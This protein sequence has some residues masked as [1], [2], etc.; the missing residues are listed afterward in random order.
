MSLWQ[1]EVKQSLLRAAVP[2]F[3]L[4]ANDG[5]HA[6]AHAHTQYI[7]AGE[8]RWPDFLRF[9]MVSV[10]FLYLERVEEAISRQLSVISF[11]N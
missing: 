1:P 8:D 4:K 9:H 7:H 11:S 6:V 3:W 5:P 2:P 10:R